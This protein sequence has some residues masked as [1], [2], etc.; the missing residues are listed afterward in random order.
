MDVPHVSLKPHSYPEI[1]HITI[2]ILSM[3][4]WYTSNRL[5]SAS[6]FMVIFSICY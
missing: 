3:Y 1:H 4:R 6:D 5:T 2:E